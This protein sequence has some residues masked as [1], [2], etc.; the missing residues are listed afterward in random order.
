MGKRPLMRGLAGQNYRP[1]KSNIKIKKIPY[2]KSKHYVDT[3][4]R[5]IYR[6]ER[7]N[8]D[9]PM[10]KDKVMNANIKARVLSDEE[11]KS[12]GF[13][14]RPFHW[15]LK[16]KVSHIET[17]DEYLVITI[18]KE[19]NGIN[20]NVFDDYTEN[21]YDYQSQ[22]YDNEFHEYANRIH[23]NVQEIMMRLVEAGVILG[24][25]KNDYI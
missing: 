9:V 14:E 12:L 4:K 10:R 20:I 11:M 24:Y 19:K 13:I 15:E 8:Y 18:G 22:L 16:E 2:E 21:I 5:G 23:L 7:I 6:I 25:E 17:M 1:S 3:S